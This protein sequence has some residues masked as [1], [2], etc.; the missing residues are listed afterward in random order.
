L[1]VWALLSVYS[2]ALGLWRP[3]PAKR[4]RSTSPRVQLSLGLGAPG[5][6]TG[7]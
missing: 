4:A 5:W 7:I 2:E 3:A 1:Y 6:A